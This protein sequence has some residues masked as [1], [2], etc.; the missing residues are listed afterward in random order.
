MALAGYAG[1]THF[2]R[3]IAGAV[4]GRSYVRE[5]AACFPAEMI[6]VNVCYKNRV[7]MFYILRPERA[8]E[9]RRHVKS[10]GKRIDQHRSAANIQQNPGAAQPGY[11]CTGP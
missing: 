3:D 1:E 6:I 10:R 2:L 8:A 11:F 5:S 7:G 9:Q 4:I